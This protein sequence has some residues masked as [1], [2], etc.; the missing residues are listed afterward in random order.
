MKLKASIIAS[1]L[2]LVGGLIAGTEV[3]NELEL[4][5]FIP[6]EGSSKLDPF[7]EGKEHNPILNLHTPSLIKEV[8]DHRLVLLKKE[9]GIDYSKHLND[10]HILLTSYQ[11][12]GKFYPHVEPNEAWILLS[13]HENPFDQ[14]KGVSLFLIPKV[15]KEYLIVR[16]TKPWL[17]LNP[18][19]ADKD[20]FN[21][22][23]YINK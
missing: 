7:N 23:P 6:L 3:K 8:T 14:K 15:K 10:F 22:P 9:T 5:V 13:E 16:K 19:D 2:F 17:Y 20:Y 18:E 21:Q 1:V 11:P 4:I 12:K